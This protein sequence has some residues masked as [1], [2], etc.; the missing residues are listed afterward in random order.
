MK[1]RQLT[2]TLVVLASLILLGACGPKATQEPAQSTQATPGAALDRQG[3]VDLMGN[4]LAALVKHDPG[5]VPFAEKVKFTENTAEIPV[6]K[7]L[8]V[9]ASGGPSEFQ[10]YA[11]DPVAQQVACLVMMKEVNKDV[12]LGARLKVENGKITEAEHLAI[13]DLGT[14]PMGQSALDNLKTPRPGLVEDVP[15][16]ERMSRDDLI[17]IGLTY[18]D[19]LTGE[20]G[21]LSP[22]AEEC[23]RHENGGTTAGG[24]PRPSGAAQA[25]VQPDPQLEK[26]M[27]AM[28]DLGPVPNTCE[29]Q[30]S[31]GT[32]SYITDIKN[33]RV[34][35]GDEQKGL[36]VGFSMFY[37]DSS[38]KEYKF[39]GPKGETMLPSYQGVFN[40][41]AM[42]IYKIRNGKI[43]D[44]E[45]IGFTMPYGLGSGWE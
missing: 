40:L 20:D 11:A 25:T 5:A 44:I 1:L 39:K 35:I 32:F 14:S 10:I 12:L 3:L 2:I 26:M 16:A 28:A 42:H 21:K 19:A 22:F 9:T 36:S 41:P 7:G 45:A 37:H 24:K 6:G 15:E 18:Y 33:R 29:A 23:E 4:Y 43:Y 38:L 13:R 8:W 17:R 31:T 30:I 34:L 27:K